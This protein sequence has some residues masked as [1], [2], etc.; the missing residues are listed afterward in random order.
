MKL[1]H[2]FTPDFFNLPPLTRGEKK[3]NWKELESN[4][5]HLVWQALPVTARPWLFLAT[6]SFKIKRQYFHKKI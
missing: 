2:F 3:N 4:P 6:V 1:K 5:G